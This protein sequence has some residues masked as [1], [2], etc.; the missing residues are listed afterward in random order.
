[1]ASYKCTLLKT[2][3]GGSTHWAPHKPHGGFSLGDDITFGSPDG[4]WKVSFADSPF[5]P[6]PIVREFGGPST[7]E[8]RVTIVRH[9]DYP[10]RCALNVGG[11]AVMHWNGGGG[12]GDDIKIP[13]PPGPQQQFRPV[14]AN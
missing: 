1:M 2:A 8:E 5:D 6:L 7:H 3:G 4:V 9:G 12:H 10:C 11:L 14:T 13:P